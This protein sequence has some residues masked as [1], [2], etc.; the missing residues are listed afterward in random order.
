MKWKGVCGSALLMHVLLLQ[1][2]SGHWAGVELEPEHTCWNVGDTVR[3]EFECADT[4]QVYQ[5]AFPFTVNGDYPFH[6][7]YLHAILRAP[8]G[9]ESVIPNEFILTD[10]MGA[11]LVESSGETATFQLKVAEGLRFNQVG[12]YSLRLLH[13]MRDDNLCGVERVGMSLDPIPMQ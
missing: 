10:R 13:Y 5:L 8:S 4:Q 7:V 6:N 12:K 1:A 2:C 11:W 3:L 9:D